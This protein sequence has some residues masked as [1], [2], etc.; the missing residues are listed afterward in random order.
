MWRETNVFG[1]LVSPLIA[2]MIAAGLIY[3]PLRLAAVRLRLFRW[4]WHPP[5]AEVGLYI[6]IV[7]SL[8]AWL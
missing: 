7:G 1:V 2:Y 6:C 8:V 3:A 4:V 5:L